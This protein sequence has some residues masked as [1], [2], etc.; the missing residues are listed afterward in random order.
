[1]TA[2]FFTMSSSCDAEEDTIDDEEV[3]EDED[4]DEDE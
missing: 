3:D 2:S 4:R 1:M